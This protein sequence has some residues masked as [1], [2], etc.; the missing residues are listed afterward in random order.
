[1]PKGHR[2]LFSIGPAAK[3]LQL[4]ERRGRSSTAMRTPALACGLDTV[5]KSSGIVES[6][7]D[8]PFVGVE[9]IE[10]GSATLEGIGSATTPR[11][12]GMPPASLPPRQPSVGQVAHAVAVKHDPVAVAG[13]SGI[14]RRHTMPETTPRALPRASYLHRTRTEAVTL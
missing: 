11:T 6:P 14:P 9:T 13:E 2:P 8:D 4:L 10:P 3:V 12:S 1:M 5:R 7:R